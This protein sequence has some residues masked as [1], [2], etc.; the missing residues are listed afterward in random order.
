MTSKTIRRVILVAAAVTGVSLAA[1]A[2]AMA[3]GNPVTANATVTE[4]ITISGLSPSIT[5]PPVGS[6]L[7]TTAV[8][9]E[10]YTV[11]A[12]SAHGYT[13]TITPAAS[14]LSDG[15]GH[16]IDNSNVFVTETTG[17]GSGQFSGSA[18]LQVG[19]TTA[20]SSD[21]Y[22]ENWGLT[23]PGSAAAGSYS[24]TFTYL[25]LGNA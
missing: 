1:A 13:L 4:S 6:G 9:A 19:H 21:S 14:A 18:P 7:S 8:G 24:E 5:F 3:A 15:A 12:N 22:S 20:P 11:S 25:A 23:V 2:P 16:S 17:P 10:N